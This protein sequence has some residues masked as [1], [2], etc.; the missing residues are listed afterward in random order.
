[1]PIDKYQNFTFKKNNERIQC[2][3]GQKFKKYMLKKFQ[4]Q[5]A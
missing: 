3:R 2:A 4:M 1:M 5:F